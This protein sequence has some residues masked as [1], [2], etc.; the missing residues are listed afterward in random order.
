MP[1]ATVNSHKIH[2]LEA[3]ELGYDVDSS[4]LPIILIHG[5]GS[6]ENYY[7]PVLE[8]LAGH[9][10]VV[11]TTYGAGQSKSRGEKLT[12]EEL[13]ADVLA[14]M[15]LLKIEK[16]VIGGHSMGGPLALTVAA[17]SPER[18]AGVVAI[19]PVSRTAN[20]GAV[21]N[22]YILI[23]FLHTGQP[24][25]DQTGNFHF[26]HRD[27]TERCADQKETHRWLIYIRMNR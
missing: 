17:K 24:V 19:G 25:L 16:A 1:F 27:C 22:K 9:R 2:Y 14:L 3:T 20:L 10:V 15:D 26:S 23:L 6:S 11:P 4:K 12:L 5:L 18:V 21:T 7:L 13:A 8:Q